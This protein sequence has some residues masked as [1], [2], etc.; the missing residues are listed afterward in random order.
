MATSDEKALLQKFAGVLADFGEWLGKRFKGDPLG[1]KRALKALADD[2]GGTVKEGAPAFS[3]PALDGIKAYRDSA[4]PGLEAWF[5]VISDV[6]A[7]YE[8]IRAIGESIDLGPEA[9]AEEVVQTVLDFLA[10]SYVRERWPHLH[11]WMEFARF[12]TEPATLFGPHGTAKKR[13]AG[14]IK[15]LLKFALAPLTTLA[16]PPMQTEADARKWS[17][18]TLLHLGAVFAFLSHSAREIGLDRAPENEQLIKMF[19]GWDQPPELRGG[20]ADD[21]SDRML[22][23]QVLAPPQGFADDAVKLEG[24]ARFSLA[25]IPAAHAGR[26]FFVSFGATA[27]RGKVQLRQEVGSRDRSALRRTVRRAD[28]RARKIPR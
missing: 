14:S 12:S 11:A 5:G 8:S 23:I 25:W 6:R 22:S 2:L 17:D 19:Y 28:R 21:V 16:G 20:G 7:L 9:A 27:L 24:A 26:G 18:S 10:G 4:N 13:F 1:Q 15:A 3:P